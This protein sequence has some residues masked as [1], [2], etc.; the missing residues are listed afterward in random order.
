MLTLLENNTRRDKKTKEMMAN[1]CTCLCQQSEVSNA[2]AREQRDGES[3]EGINA[4]K[5]DE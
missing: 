2:R 5:I 1:W 3:E 4:K